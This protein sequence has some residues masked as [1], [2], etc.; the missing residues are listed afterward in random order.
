MHRKQNSFTSNQSTSSCCKGN[1]LLSKALSVEAY[2]ALQRLP[3]PWQITLFLFM[4]CFYCYTFSCH[5]ISLYNHITISSCENSSCYVHFSYDRHINP[6]LLKL[7][8]KQV[9]MSETFLSPLKY[10]WL[11]DSSRH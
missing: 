6:F 5:V 1:N 4:L 11:L 8:Q 3:K 7:N 2:N 9:S 10:S